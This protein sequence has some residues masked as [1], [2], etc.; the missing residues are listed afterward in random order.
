[1]NVLTACV[2]SARLCLAISRAFAD[3]GIRAEASPQPRSLGC[4]A[5]HLPCPIEP[6]EKHHIWITIHDDISV[7]AFLEATFLN[8]DFIMAVMPAAQS[9]DDLLTLECLVTACSAR[10][11]AQ[12]FLKRTTPRRLQQAALAESKKP[13]RR[14]IAEKILGVPS[15]PD[16]LVGFADDLVAGPHPCACAQGA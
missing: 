6:A 2:P 1:M 9:E 15:L 3:L 10:T 8:A 14:H 5:E 4:I 11:I 7:S 12:A 16:L 13:G